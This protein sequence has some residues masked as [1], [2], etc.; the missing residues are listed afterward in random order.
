M[1][2]CRDEFLGFFIAN[3]KKAPDLM[4]FMEICMER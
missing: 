2:K 3:E 1:D 4:L